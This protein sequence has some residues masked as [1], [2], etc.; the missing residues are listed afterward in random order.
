MDI[1]EKFYRDSLSED[2]LDR[3]LFIKVDSIIAKFENRLEIL[4]S[5]LI[6]RVD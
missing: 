5:E 6:G 4:G 3:K 2:N 1:Y